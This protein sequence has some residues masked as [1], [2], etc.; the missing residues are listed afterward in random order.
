MTMQK[1]REVGKN[2]SYEAPKVL[3]LLDQFSL[4]GSLG[5]TLTIPAAA[6]FVLHPYGAPTLSFAAAL[7]AVLV[8]VG[9][10]SIALGGAAH[11]GA[12]T[13]T[14][15]MVLLRGLFGN[16]GSR[17]PT[18]LNL[19]Q[20]L[21]WTAVEVLVIA[22]AAKAV[23]G[24][25]LVL[26]TLG[27]GVFAT[28]MAIKPLG[29]VRVLRRYALVG[30]IIATGYLLYAVVRHGVHLS[31]GGWSGFWLAVDV[32]IAL[33]IS[34]APL[35]A[36]YSRHSRTPRKAFLGTVVGF[37]LGAGAYFVLGLLALVTIVASNQQGDPYAFSQALLVL[38][39]GIFALL[40]L[41]V[42]EIDEAFANVYSTVASIQNL[43][44]L[45]DRRILAIAVGVISTA[46][47]LSLNVVGYESFLFAIGAVF[48]PLFAV[49]LVDWFLV[50]KG[51]WDLSET[52]KLRAWTLIPWAIG[53]IVYQ[54]INPGSAPLWSKLWI[55]IDTAIHFTP[56]NWMSASILSFLVAALLTLLIGQ[57]VKRNR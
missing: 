8:G 57:V 40:I 26:W 5:I 36:D 43:R 22:H 51:Q 31:H 10:G 44:P 46:V 52:S 42:D 20:C 33:P 21:G 17:F 7:L 55:N 14:P 37:F 34:W 25:S 53:F 18:I 35:A 12:S 9:A 41:I 56:A 15:S 23:V 50:S 27:A 47:A 2:L 30:A 39:L 4:W 49:V 1:D 13:G 38:P 54:L 45:W 28:L 24:G 19:L 29:S 48:V 6:V 3:S 11:I 32:A 16:R